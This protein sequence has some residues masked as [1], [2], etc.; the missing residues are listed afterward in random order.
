MIKPIYYFSIGSILYTLLNIYL[1]Y[2]NINWDLVNIPIIIT[3]FLFYTIC[4]LSVSEVLLSHLLIP[5]NKKTTDLTVFNENPSVIINYNLKAY[6]STEIDLC[7]SNMYNAYINN[8]FCNTVAVLISVTSDQHLREYELLLM[9]NYRNQIYNYLL[10]EGE[11]YLKNPNNTPTWKHYI[12]SKTDLETFCKNK[13]SNFILVYR[14][15]NILKKCGQYQDLITLSEGYVRAYTYI[16]TSIYYNICRRPDKYLSFIDINDYNKIYNKE[17]K[18]TLVLDADTIVPENFISN[19]V[20]IAESNPEYT[21]YQPNIELTN[22]NTIFQHIQKI[23]LQRSNI[24]YAAVSRFFNHSSF[25][26]KGLINNKKYLEQCIGTPENLIEFVPSNALSHDTFESICMPVMFIPNHSLFEEPP[27]TYLSWNFRELRWNMGEIIVFY[28]LFPKLFYKKFHYKR[29]TFKLSFKTLFFG[30]SAFRI[31]IMW[32]FLLI[33][34]ILNSFIP[35]YNF[36]LSYGYILITSILIPNI[37]SFYFYKKKSLT[38]IF[39]SFI[40][41]LPEPLIGT[42]RLILSLHK[43]F[44]ENIIWLP[45]NAIEQNILNK[46]II[47]SSIYYFGPYSVI[48]IIL[49]ILYYHIN[50]LLSLFLISIVLLPLYNIITNYRLIS[51]FRIGLRKIKV[52]KE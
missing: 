47:I 28:H 50:I 21:I 35:Y 6:T 22:I 25:F 16:D 17:Y 24:S 13:A 45:S 44:T 37:I 46:G 7:F 49:F 40:H 4:T 27:R 51:K 31:M 11:K 2:I 20:N 12:F 36:Y 8:I 26:G 34:I 15:T 30:L 23:W 52:I 3:Y 32:P 1:T 42:T 33:F 29:Q 48:A 39:T 14:D 18:Y 38:F 10:I 9:Q 5:F 43:V 41:A 19:V